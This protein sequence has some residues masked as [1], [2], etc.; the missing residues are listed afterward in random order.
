MLVKV[1]DRSEQLSEAQSM[2]SAL[3]LLLATK[4]SSSLQGGVKSAAKEEAWKQAVSITT[5]STSLVF[6]P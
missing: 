6:L 5:L 2:G 3:S 4:P 1:Q